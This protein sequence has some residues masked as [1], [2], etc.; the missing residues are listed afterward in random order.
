MSDFFP[1]AHGA[2]ITLVIVAIIA[3]A[4]HSAPSKGDGVYGDDC[5]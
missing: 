4:A 3:I 1:V 2:L 5:S